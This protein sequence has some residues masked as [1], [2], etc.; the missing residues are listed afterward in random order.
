MGF[1]IPFK[2]DYIHLE[3]RNYF[4]NII[5]NGFIFFGGVSLLIL[6]IVIDSIKKKS[7]KSSLVLSPFCIVA[8]YITIASTQCK[9]NYIDIAVYHNDEKV[10]NKLVFQYFEVGIGGN[11][12]SRALLTAN[13]L[14]PIRKIQV[15]DENLIPDSLKYLEGATQ[16]LFPK[17]LIIENKLYLF[18]KFND[19]YK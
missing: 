3:P 2:I 19:R 7:Y 11:P 4:G 5:A 14:A 6:L 9:P 18:E 12:R 13:E 1:I 8:I 16:S 10:D 17:S 15:L